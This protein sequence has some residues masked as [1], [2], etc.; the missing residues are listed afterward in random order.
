[1]P[2]LLLQTARNKEFTE[3]TTYIKTVGI[4]TYRQNR[5]P[6]LHSNHWCRRRLDISW[7]LLK[8]R[9]N[10]LKRYFPIKLKTFW[11]T[12]L[13]DFSKVVHLNEN[14]IFTSLYKKKRKY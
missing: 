1:L 3:K 10:I 6:S 14:I 13:Y 5:C 4:S 12:L 9:L 7:K 11:N 2:L 8:W